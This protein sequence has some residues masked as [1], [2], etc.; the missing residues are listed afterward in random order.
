MFQGMNARSTRGRFLRTALAGV[1]AFM[2]LFHG[3]VMT[4]AKA[5]SGAPESVR[6][7]NADHHHH[8]HH[9]AATNEGQPPDSSPLPT[10][11]AFGCFV[12]VEA[13]P[14]RIAAAFFKPIGTLSPAIVGAMRPAE[15][16]PAV[17]PPRLQV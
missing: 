11:N 17:P 16:E 14:A 1:F 15:I 5:A 9:G 13:L 6:I 10:C 4:F 12:L 7:V 8:H 2:T 3:P